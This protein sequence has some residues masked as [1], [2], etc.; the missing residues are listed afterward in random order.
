MSWSF[1]KI[2]IVNIFII[3]IVIIITEFS[4]NFRVLK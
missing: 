3:T 1:K 4:G 2:F